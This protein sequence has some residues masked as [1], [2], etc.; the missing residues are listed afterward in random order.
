MLNSAHFPHLLHFDHRPL[1]ALYLTTSILSFGLSLVGIFVPIYL[2][3]LTGNFYYLPA[4]YG[5]VSLAA[6]LSLLIAPV[7]L[8]RWGAAR[9][10]L[11]ANV[12]RILSLLFLLLAARNPVLAFLSAA[13][14][15]LVIPT[16]WVTYHSVFLAS[17]KDGDFGRKIAWM[18]ILISVV[19]ALAPFFGGLVIAT[20]GF[21]VLYGL[22]MLFIL[23][24]SIPIFWVGDHL[25]FRF[26]KPKQILAETFSRPWRPVLTGF[27]GIRL[28]DMVAAIFFTLFLFEIVKS[29]P[30]L[31]A[32]TSVFAVVKVIL[33]VAG[34]RAVDTLGSRRVFK[35]GALLLAPFWLVAGF[36]SNFMALTI[37]NAYRGA[38]APF[39]G[40]GAESLF[41]SLARKDHFLSILKREVSIHI[42]IIL[43]V[44]LCALLWYFFPANWPILFLPAAL[45]SLIAIALVKAK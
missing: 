3:Q 26:V 41:Y 33:M 27:L 43:A 18:G 1:N 28:E 39:Y 23:L 42:T 9:T 13:F 21:P 40:I 45:G 34:G 35:V 16:F 5:V 12:F 15:G 7:F 29:F 19:A 4:Y 11:L 10:V 22:G 37:V 31:G 2:F 25:G 8:P 24:S 38:L 6:L 20:F 17:G 32:V 44:L 14:E 30:N 36:L